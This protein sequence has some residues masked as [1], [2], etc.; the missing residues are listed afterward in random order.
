MKR[1]ELQILI[2]LDIVWAFAC[3]STRTAKVT[4]LR[5]KTDDG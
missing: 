2:L 1:I 3:N 5:A 4:A